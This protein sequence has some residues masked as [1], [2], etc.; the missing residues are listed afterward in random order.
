MSFDVSQTW[1][2]I[3]QTLV[4]VRLNPVTRVFF[5]CHTRNLV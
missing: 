2:K 1:K 4:G 3:A 5:T